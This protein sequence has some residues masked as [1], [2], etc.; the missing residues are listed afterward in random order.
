MK[1]AAI[2]GK[3]KYYK[4]DYK[5]EDELTEVFSK[6]YQ[7]IVSEKSLWIP[8]EKQLK[9]RRFKNFKHSVGD[10]FLLVWDNPTTPTLYITE[11]ELK[12]HD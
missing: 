10:G 3:E 4:H 12:K 5:E 11:I 7:Q 2:K 6:H 1:Y 9:S 8:I